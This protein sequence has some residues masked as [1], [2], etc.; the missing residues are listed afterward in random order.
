MTHNNQKDRKSLLLNNPRGL[1]KADGVYCYKL[2]KAS[3]QRKR[4][5]CRGEQV[6]RVHVR[7]GKCSSHWGVFMSDS[8]I[9]IA[10]FI[11][12][13]K[14]IIILVN[15]LSISGGS[16][17]HFS[18]ND[19]LQS[20]SIFVFQCPRSILDSRVLLTN[21]FYVWK[22]PAMSFSSAKIR[23]EKCFDIEGNPLFIKTSFSQYFDTHQVIFFSD[24]RT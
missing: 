5:V 20:T 19:K 15:S 12:I 8:Y 21:C 3:V 17:F 18:Q 13:W 22:P 2:F 6:Y 14:S 16:G 1:L 7:A 4:P 24:P 23:S 9:S 11:G 10:W